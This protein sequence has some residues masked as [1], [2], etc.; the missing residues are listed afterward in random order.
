MNYNHLSA[1]PALRSNHIPMWKIAFRHILRQKFY[2]ILNLLGLAVGLGCCLLMMLYLVDEFSYDRFHEKADRI[3]RIDQTNIWVDNGAPFGSTGPAV[4]HALKA[5][6]P[7]LEAVTRIHTPGSVW[8]SQQDEKGDKRTFDE[9]NILAADSNVFDIFSFDMLAGNPK[10][11]LRDPQSLVLTETA[12]KRYFG[13]TDVLGKQLLIR[14]NNEETNFTI[15][16][17]VAD[18]PHASHIQFDVLLSMTSFPRVKRQEGWTWIWTTFVT[19][20]LFEEGADMAKVKTK[21]DEIPPKY[22]ETTLENIMNITYDDF[23]KQGKVWE[24]FLMPLQDIRLYS[25]DTSNRLGPT[26]DIKQLTILGIVALLI[27]ILSCINFMNLA[28]AR[29]SRRA[30]EIGVKKVLG[31]HKSALIQQFL[32]ES[33]LFSLL[34][35]VLGLAL[36]ELT[37]QPFN[38]LAA[39]ELA[40]DPFL[41]PWLIPALFGLSLFMG[42]LAGSYPAFYLTAF[43]PVDVLKGSVQQGMKSKGMRNALVT[44]QFTIS[45]GLIICTLFVYEQLQFTRDKDLGFEP[46]NLLV[47]QNIEQLEARQEVFKEEILKL[48]FVDKAANSDLSPPR[49]YSQDYFKALDGAPDQEI[50][51]S[52]MS[53]DADYLKTLGIEL[54]AGRNFRKDQPAEAQ[55]VIINEAA[56]RAMGWGIPQTEGYEAPL[57]KR[58]QYLGDNVEPFEVIGILKDFH[59]WSLHQEIEPLAIFVHEAPIWSQGQNYLSIRLDE[60][61]ES[62]S[63]LEDAIAEVNNIW[64]EMVPGTPFTYSFLDQDFFESFQEEQRLGRVMGIFTFLAIF[65]ACLGLLGL[66]AF[67]VEQRRQEI[68]IRKVLGAHPMQIVAMLSRSVITWILLAFVIATP[69]TIWLVNGWLETFAYRISVGPVAFV[70]AGGITIL[71]AMLTMSFHA[72]QATR[73]NPVEALRDE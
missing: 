33:M 17:L 22:T 68:G 49:I 35:T 53:V 7:E 37:I 27:L 2:A 46:D 15:N 72:W 25:G 43:K 54:T 12:A 42:L 57:G 23:L 30:R 13:H 70:L 47:I 64:T 6:I 11:A 51:V 59:F 52:F 18:I 40:I 61:I 16:G 44:F 67:S 38:T 3:Y 8:L 41:H 14:Q 71:V 31:A 36:A 28:T 1:T 21:L 39:K 66:T 20:A 10:T 19:Y 55:R 73:I 24:L 56:V 63:Q 50:P 9:E 58:V 69:L 48:S 5:E 29:A 65:I 45:I 34:A 4:M 62:A 32:V 26:G 60:G